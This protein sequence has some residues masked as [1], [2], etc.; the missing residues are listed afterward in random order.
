[1]TDSDP[2]LGINDI[3]TEGSFDWSDNSAAN[4]E[5]WSP[6]NPDNAAGNQDCGRIYPTGTWDDDLC[7]KLKTFICKKDI[8]DSNGTT[9]T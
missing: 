4:F 6:G 5:Y 8:E 3:N 9:S 2:W 1:M 7:D